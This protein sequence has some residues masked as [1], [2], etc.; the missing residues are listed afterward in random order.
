[1]INF[2]SDQFLHAYNCYHCRWRV[3]N[4]ST[5]G[6]NLTTTVDS[7]WV[8]YPLNLLVTHFYKEGLLRELLAIDDSHWDGFPSTAELEAGAGTDARYQAPSLHGCAS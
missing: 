3:L 1:M 5:H 2:V 7:I 6:C 8:H 4:C